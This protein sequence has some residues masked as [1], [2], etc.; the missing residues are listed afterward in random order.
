MCRKTLAMLFWLLPSVVYAACEPTFEPIPPSL[1]IAWGPEPATQL[2]LDKTDTWQHPT[3]SDGHH[4][5]ARQITDQAQL[6]AAGIRPESLNSRH[7]YSQHSAFSA[8]GRWLISHGAKQRVLFDGMQYTVVRA[9]TREHRMDDWQWD[10]EDDNT[11]YYV[12]PGRGVVARYDVALDTHETVVD[13][14]TVAQWLGV[15]DTLALEGNF[16][17]G[18]MSAAGDRMVTK[19][20]L[21]SDA[22]VVVFNPRSG[23]YITHARFPGMAG[24][25]KMDW[26][27]LSPS[28]RHIVILGNFDGLYGTTFARDKRTKQV[29]VFATDKFETDGGRL[30]MGRSAH[31][32]YLRDDRGRDILV[33]V[34]SQPPKGWKGLRSHVG[35]LEQGLYT[36]D[37][38][39]LEWRERLSF[40]QRFPNGIPAAH[41]SASPNDSRVVVSFYQGGTKADAPDAQRSPLLMVDLG[42]T[43]T[44]RV[45][46]VGWDLAANPG[47]G[48]SKRGY[49]A[50]PHA[51]F[52]PKLW[53]ANGES[54]LKI[55]WASDNNKPKQVVG[56]MMVAEMVCNADSTS[57]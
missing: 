53:Y 7:E 42:G 41:V 31:V 50:Q 38:D 57:E 16:G 24:Q 9:I 54:G 25:A 44:D 1:A 19:F 15:N 39:T 40:K 52:T 17:Q 36:I 56:D 28:G 37:L 12:A 55:A 51:S 23:D 47:L 3:L 34:G 20:T 49:L 22:I 26:Q 45:A 21:G 14:A 29:R 43:H 32:D 8:K 11:A 46:W 13:T 4:M 33:L 2:T 35:G 5:R 48:N 30:A 10:P 18:A 27:A 6:K